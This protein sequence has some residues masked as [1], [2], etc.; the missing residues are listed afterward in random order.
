MGIFGNDRYIYI[1]DNH[2]NIYVYIYVNMWEYMENDGDRWE[3]LMET[4]DK[5][6]LSIRKRD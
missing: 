4:C 3:D 1:W 6:K 2:G 5:W